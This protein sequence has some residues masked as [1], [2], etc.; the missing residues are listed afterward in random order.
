[1]PQG[2]ENRLMTWED[3]MGTPDDAVPLTRVMA[4]HALAM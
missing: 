3:R 2:A 4:L 1:M